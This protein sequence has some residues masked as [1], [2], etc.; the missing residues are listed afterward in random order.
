MKHKSPDPGVGCSALGS[1]SLPILVE[2]DLLF[3][4]PERLTIPE[5]NQ[6][7]AQR[8]RIESGRCIY[9]GHRQNQVVEMIDNESHTQTLIPRRSLP[10]MIDL[11][12]AVAESMPVIL[13][14]RRRNRWV[15]E[16]RVAMIS[17]GAPI[18]ISRRSLVATR[19]CRSVP[20]TTRRRWDR[21]PC[22]APQRRET[23]AGLLRIGH[24]EPE[25]RFPICCL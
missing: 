15:A 3:S 20:A 9:V 6:F 4:K 18:E 5:R 10:M 13:D 11:G 24:H 8:G 1:N 16:A 22:L 25:E 12:I 23:R 21:S 19:S 7:H 14:Q 2:I 17:R